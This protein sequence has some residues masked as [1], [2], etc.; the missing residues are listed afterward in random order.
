[1]LRIS[2]METRMNDCTNG[3]YRYRQSLEEVAEAGNKHREK[4]IALKAIAE[5]QKSKISILREEK[6]SLMENID[7]L[8]HDK[9]IDTDLILSMTKEN[10]EL[11]RDLKD[12]RMKA[13]EQEELVREHKNEYEVNHSLTVKLKDLEDENFLKDIRY[14]N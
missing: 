12:H 9:N 7:Q 11:K 6:Y 8:E 13:I 10:R 4:V 1:M 5:E 2:M 3:C 14:L